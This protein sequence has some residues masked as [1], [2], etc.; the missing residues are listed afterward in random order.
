[1]NNDLGRTMSNNKQLFTQYMQKTIDE[2]L[3]EFN[4]GTDGLSNSQI[5]ENQKKYG[6]NE[7]AEHHKTWIWMLIKQVNNAFF[8]TFFAIALVSLLIGEIYNAL[9]IISFILFN[10][11]VSFFQEFHATQELQKLKQYLIHYVTV[12]RDGTKRKI[13]STEVVPGD[14]IILNPGDMIS[15]DVRFIQTEHL[16][17][18][19]SVLTGESAPVSKTDKELNPSGQIYDAAN[20]GFAGTI[21]SKGNALGVIFATGADT[22]MGHLAHLT[23]E[24]MQ[25]SSFAKSI[26]Q[27]SN[28]IVI[29]VLVT[30]VIIFLTNIILKG[31]QANI[32]ELFMFSTA[33]AIAVIP[34]ALPVIITFC[35]A[36]GVSRLAQKKVIVRRLSAI[37]SMGSIEVLCADKTGTLTENMMTVAE[38]NCADP[39]KIIFFAVLASEIPFDQLPKVQTGFDYAVWLALTEQQRTELFEYK[40]RKSIAFEPSSRRNTTVITKDDKTC[41]VILRGMLEEIAAR[42]NLSEQQFNDFKHWEIDQGHQGHR[43]LA[44]GYKENTCELLKNQN[45]DAQEQDIEFLGCISFVDPL[46][47]TA[48]QA[49]DRA[50]SLGIQIKIISGDSKEVCVAVG[51]EVGLIK[52]YDEVMTGQELEKLDENEKRKA[53]MQCTVFARILPE[54]KFEIIK[55]LKEKFEVGYMGDG[56]NDGP[57][58][59]IA[60]VS[61]AVQ[62]SV[63]IAQQV[64]DIILLKKSL[65]IIINGI[66]EGRI[67]FANTLKYLKTSLASTF[68]NF[69]SLAIVSLFLEYLPML[70]IQLLVLNI[71]AD[72]PMIAISTDSVDFQDIQSPEK[73]YIKNILIIA[74]VLG[75]VSSLFDFIYFALF[76]SYAPATLRT[77]WFLLSIAT[78]LMF[79]FSMRTRRLFYKADRPSLALSLF[80]FLSLVISLLLIFTP[81]GHNYFEFVPLNGSQLFTIFVIVIAY[82]CTTELIKNF[83]YRWPLITNEK[84]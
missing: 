1:M 41:I 73:H 7:I 27:I 18:D 3:Q 19:E 33:L 30:L 25:E 5:P 59:K 70:P 16:M 31:R 71:V 75:V 57:A 29:L 22:Q 15:A 81:W 80:A 44:I 32:F 50:K 82:F 23:L 38:I 28:F 8:Y 20:I 54:Q 34:E 76:R 43:V 21:V 63:D 47:K 51:K 83:L 66:Q 49:I 64:A 26:Q 74:C 6:K 79:L 58:L 68:G 2:I 36:Q 69:Y 60:D 53:S 45:R 78:E 10:A 14:I 13:K 12:V 35:L 4:S 40:Q 84:K 48:K 9:I 17:I 52:S 67:I 39:Q 37:E 42:S 24:N 77:G 72:M 55:Y 56:I 46:K 11:L 62:G 61:I 65:M